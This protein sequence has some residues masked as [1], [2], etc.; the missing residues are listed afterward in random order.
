M[1]RAWCKM[2]MLM[3]VAAPSAA[4][5]QSAVPAEV[6]PADFTA[7]Q[8]VDSRGCVFWRDGSDRWQAR[9]ARDGTQICGYP[10]SSSIRGLNGRPRLV[11]L[12]PDAGR[13]RAER[14]ERALSES[15]ITNLRPGELT[16]DPR[17][18]EKLPDL[19]PEPGS[20]APGEALKAAVAAAPALRRDMAGALQPNRR[21]CALL[22]HDAGARSGRTGQDPTQGF[23]DSLS[24]LD[25]ARLS[26]A[27]PLGGP[28]V[29]LPEA[30]PAADGAP[31]PRMRQD[32][33][34]RAAATA[35]AAGRA[36]ARQASRSRA[37]PAEAAADMIPAGARF[38]QMGPFPDPAAA[39]RAARHAASL[40]LPVR[41]ARSNSGGRQVPVALAGPFDSREAIVRALHALRQ[42]GHAAVPRR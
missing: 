23:C 35:T 26:F 39:A 16:S 13:S 27:R 19:G 21:L 2:L 32:S 4:L 11:A 30:A 31:P 8:Y 20:T 25:L 40:G 5:A 24:E 33:P 42:A 36:P 7:R 28:I 34:H 6:P 14:L 3:L 38:L 12:D 9:L 41:P 29:T 18:M 15:V 1:L 17:P 22:G 37:A 10:P